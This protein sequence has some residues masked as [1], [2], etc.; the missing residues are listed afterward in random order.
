MPKYTSVRSMLTETCSPFGWERIG[1]VFCSLRGFYLAP[2]LRKRVQPQHHRS[3]TVQ[4]LGS[5]SFRLYF[6]KLQSTDGSVSRRTLCFRPT[7]ELLFLSQVLIKKR[8][9]KTSP[10]SW[11]RVEVFL[12]LSFLHRTTHYIVLIWPHIE[13]D[14]LKLCKNCI[15]VFILLSLSGMFV[16]KI[17]IKNQKW[18]FGGG[19]N[20]V[21][22]QPFT[23]SVTFSMDK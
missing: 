12:I 13:T 2:H 18:K 8:G 1:F 17:S 9:F 22:H 11:F 3:F 20:L 5:C 4:V 7:K 21:L 10:N 19:H 14:F 6:R 23:I 16:D 15:H